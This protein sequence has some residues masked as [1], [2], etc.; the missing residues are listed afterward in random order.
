MET[1]IKT[2]LIIGIAIVV[3]AFILG[4]SFKNRN[5]NLDSISVIGL[6]TKDFVSDEIL[7]SGSF[8]ANSLD[9][10]TAYGKIISDQKIVSEFFISKGFK[11]NEFSFGAVNFQKKF[12]EIKVQNANNEYINTEQVF[13]GYEAT[14]SIS[15]SAKKNPELMKRIETVSSKTS[16]LINSGIELT[17]NSIQ[18]TYSNLPSLK[19]S[20]IENA[21]K[22]ANERANK[23]VNTANGSIGKLKDASMGVFQI[24]GQGSTAEDSYGGNNDTFSKNKTARITVRLEYGLK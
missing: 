12:R 16:E 18:Y 17:S 9:I 10:K 23:I 2:S 15:F 3:T 5:E 11:P 24:T 4:Q 7:W 6:G 21:T 8:T 14:Q 20:L 1:K 22:D 13:D 19:Q